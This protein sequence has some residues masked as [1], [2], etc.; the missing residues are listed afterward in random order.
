MSIKGG[1]PVTK[2]LFTYIVYHDCQACEDS[3]SSSLRVLAEQTFNAQMQEHMHR[4]D[5][6][7]R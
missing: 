7:M 6:K 4:P 2:H 1:V 5:Y 3:T